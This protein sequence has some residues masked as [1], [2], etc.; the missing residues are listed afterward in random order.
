MI[1]NQQVHRTKQL[2]KTIDD[3]TIDDHIKID[4]KSMLEILSI[5][6]ICGHTDYLTAFEFDVMTIVLR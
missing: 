6:S 4:D 3:Q 2:E 5:F 1:L